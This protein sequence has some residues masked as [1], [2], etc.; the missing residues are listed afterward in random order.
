MKLFQFEAK[1]I[2]KKYGVPVP[3]GDVARN[4]DTAEAIGQEIGKPVILKS[5]ILLSGR[6]KSGCTGSREIQ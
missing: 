5:Q 4:S 3:S 1:N 6:G 2:L